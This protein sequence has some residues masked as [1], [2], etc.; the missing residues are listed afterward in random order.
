MMPDLAREVELHVLLELAPEV[1]SRGLFDVAPRPLPTGIVPA[2]PV[3]R[4]CLPQSLHRYW[5]TAA[6]LH[7]IVHNC[8]RSLH[9]AT[10]ATSYEGAR[11]VHRLRP[12]VIHMDNVSLRM[13]LMLWSWRK[14]PLVLSVHD[15]EAHSGEDNWRRELACRLTFPFVR[16]FVLYNQVWAA[17]FGA[18]L[19]VPRERIDTMRLGVHGMCRE[20]AH[21]ALPEE[22]RT[23]LF[24][25][26]LSPYKGLEVLYRA[27]EQVAQSV[28]NLRIIVAGRPE[29][30]YVPP[31]PPELPNG[32]VVEVEPRYLHN[33]EASQLFERAA[34]VVCP[35]LDATQSGV[36][37]TA[38]GFGKP[39]VATRVGGIPE[40]VEN[41]V[42][43]ELVEANDPA[44]LAEAL[45]RL[46]LDSPARLRMKECVQKSVQG[47]LSWGE[48]ARQMRRV[49][50][51][52][53]A[54]STQPAAE[55]VPS[56]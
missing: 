29:H 53:V 10:V 56:G 52:A 45:T 35:N 23:V 46:L 38:F 8:R 32:G 36:V 41:G 34:L 21:E 12:D 50:E 30:G 3:L 15:P 19:R 27:A 43:G 2:A 9:P 25:G 42:T 16:R 13:G 17:P 18:R 22:A 49:Y 44:G 48:F 47:D 5:Q 33:G 39:V 26:R 11:F 40:Y 24:F 1:W 55:G 7:F 31:P 6:S 37:L 54:R 28:E 51:R 14:T 20:W 4:E